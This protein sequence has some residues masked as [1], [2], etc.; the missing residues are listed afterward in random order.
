MKIDEAV[1]EENRQ[2]ARDSVEDVI[3]KKGQKIIEQGEVVTEN[4][5]AMLDSLGM[6]ESKGVDFTLYLGVGPVSYT[7]L[8]VYKRQSPCCLPEPTTI[9]PGKG[10]LRSISAITG[11]P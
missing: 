1:T 7:H 10:G 5:I 3:Y 11:R 6:L 4:Q 2:E 9:M 8:D